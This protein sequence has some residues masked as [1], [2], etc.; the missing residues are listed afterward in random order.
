METLVVSINQKT[1]GDCMG[2]VATSPRSCDYTLDSFSLAAAHDQINAEIWTTYLL[3]S[4]S[5]YEPL[6]RWFRQPLNSLL[7]QPL[8]F[9][10]DWMFMVQSFQRDT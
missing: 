1:V 4:D 5:T 7:Q 3:L 9:R 6:Q 10:Q 8:D 2:Y